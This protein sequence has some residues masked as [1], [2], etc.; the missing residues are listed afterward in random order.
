MTAVAV[1]A[2]ID[3]A[4]QLV[5]MQGARVGRTRSGLQLTGGSFTQYLIASYASIEAALEPVKLFK[6][7]ARDVATSAAK[8]LSNP[9][10]W[11]SRAPAAALRR[12]RLRFRVVRSGLA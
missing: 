8:F 10:T 5:L 1:G 12:E 6:G 7:A 9:S 2:G 11:I 4:E 3:A